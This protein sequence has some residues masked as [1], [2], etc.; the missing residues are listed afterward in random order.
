MQILATII[1][2]YFVIMPLLRDFLL[3]AHIFAFATSRLTQLRLVVSLSVSGT[4]IYLSNKK[5]D[6]FSPCPEGRKQK[7]YSFSRLLCG[8]KS[9]VPADKKGS[10]EE[11]KNPK[12]IKNPCFT[13]RPPHPEKNRQTLRVSFL[14]QLYFL[15]IAPSLPAKNNKNAF[16]GMLT[17]KRKELLSGSD[18]FRRSL[19]RKICRTGKRLAFVKQTLFTRG[20]FYTT[21]DKE[22][23]K[24]RTNLLFCVR[25]RTLPI[26]RARICVPPKN[27]AFSSGV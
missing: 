26:K 6:G 19:Y 7:R 22:N 24:N 17:G 2:I 25:L 9:A 1:R 20:V 10:P 5:A 23:I 11:Y 15:P 14:A 16:R 13:K 3:S 8:Q 27:F 12:N 21:G 4:Q 18:Y